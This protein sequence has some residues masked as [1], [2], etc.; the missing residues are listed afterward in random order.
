MLHAEERVCREDL[1]QVGL[2]GRPALARLLTLM[3]AAPETHL[4]L[5]DVVRL[6]GEAGLPETPAGLARKLQTLA[7]H[8]LLGRLPNT[9]A[10]QVF[11]TVP[12]PHAHLL[13]EATRQCVDLHVSAETLISIIRQALAGRADDV[14]IVIHFRASRAPE[15]P[16]A[17]A[18]QSAETPG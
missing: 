1:K 13:Y 14:D 18:R 17:E 9:M 4:G 5:A 2:P 6:A 11:D 7:D 15:P 12:Q 3:R 16:A 8:G 10:E